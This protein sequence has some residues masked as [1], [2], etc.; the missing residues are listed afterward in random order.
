MLS[1]DMLSLDCAKT[2]TGMARQHTIIILQMVFF[3]GVS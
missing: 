2:L 1:C 3:I